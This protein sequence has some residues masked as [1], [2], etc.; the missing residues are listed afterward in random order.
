MGWPARFVLLAD[1]ISSVQT[2][3]NVFIS[4]Y[5]LVL[6]VYILTSWLRL[7]YSPTLNRI[8][9]FLYDVCEPYLR[10]FRRL[11]PST[12]GIDFS[13]ILAFIALGAIDRLLIWILQHFH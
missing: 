4:L 1:A 9:R 7:P 12:G 5:A 3:I 10:L 2:F 6:L 11:L 8:Q 13:P